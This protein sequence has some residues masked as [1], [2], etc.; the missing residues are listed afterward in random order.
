MTTP[1]DSGAGQRVP[2]EAGT[3]QWDQGGTGQWRPSGTG[4][5]APGEVAG[6][7]VVGSPW[8][9]GAQTQVVERVEGPD[10]ARPAPARSPA[11]GAGRSRWARWR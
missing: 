2:G 3:S 4:P 5:W 6:T 9:P 10:G 11:G 8:E 1:E 7:A